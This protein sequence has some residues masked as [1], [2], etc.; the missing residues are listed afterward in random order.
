MVL[1]G[2][3][4]G[5]GDRRGRVYGLAD[6][7]RSVP[8]ASHAPHVPAE[9]AEAAV[10]AMKRFVLS[11]L[12]SLL[13][14][15][16]CAKQRSVHDGKEHVKVVVKADGTLFVEGTRSSLADLSGRLDVLKTK[17]GVVWYYRANPVGEP[18]PEAMAV[19]KLV[20]DKQLPIAMFSKEDF[21]EYVSLR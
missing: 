19:I 20:I 12:S 16:G 14:L 1:P 15:V 2:S 6:G 13:L 11:I 7:G 10:A 21:S 3:T 17:Q 18:S 9:R 8:V 5:A 4:D